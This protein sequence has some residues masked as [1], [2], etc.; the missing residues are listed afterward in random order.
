MALNPDTAAM[1]PRRAIVVALAGLH[2]LDMRNP[3]VAPTSPRHANPLWLPRHHGA[4]PPL[5]PMLPH[6]THRS[7]HVSTARDPTVAPAGLSRFDSV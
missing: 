7:Y 1:S 4:K 3:A 2:R 5:S 6:A